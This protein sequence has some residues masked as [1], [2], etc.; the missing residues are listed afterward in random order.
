[1]TLDICADI[2][3]IA[4]LAMTS[5]YIDE[6]CD[7]NL[8]RFLLSELPN[9]KETT[10]NIHNVVKKIFK[11]FGLD[12]NKIRA[13]GNRLRGIRCACHRWDT[14]ADDVVNA[15]DSNVEDG[16]KR[17]PISCDKINT[18]AK[19]REQIAICQKIKKGRWF[20]E[21]DGENKIAILKDIDKHLL[22]GVFARYYKTEVQNL[23]KHLPQTMAGA[24]IKWAVQ[25]LVDKMFRIWKLKFRL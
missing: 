2:Q 25:S 9:A 8:R 7:L 18:I 24:T 1:M 3:R 10:E 19:T 21:L 12:L 13:Q 20:F 6:S 17:I 23:S 11:D 5:H 22:K 16:I 14:V 4:F 15:R